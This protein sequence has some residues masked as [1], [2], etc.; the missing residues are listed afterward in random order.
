[1]VV[2]L[3]APMGEDNPL[4]DMPAPDNVKKRYGLWWW[5]L[6]ALYVPLIVARFYAYDIW[7]GMVSLI[8]AIWAYSLVQNDMKNMTQACLFFLGIIAMFQVMMDSI[9]LLTCIHG[10]TFEQQTVSPVT[11]KGSSQSVEYKVTI[12]NYPFFL[13][14]AGFMYNF[15]SALLIVIPVM[16]LIAVLLSYFTYNAFPTSMFELDDDDT[17]FG[18]GF[19]GGGYGTQGPGARGPGFGGGNSGG[20]AYNQ[21]SGSGNFRVFE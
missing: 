3:G 8:M 7:G 19:G 12:T 10:R 5:C 18:A 4:L 13:N 14:K 15:Q 1:M 21:N 17:N 6:F 9:T 20:R 2:P 16:D 11:S